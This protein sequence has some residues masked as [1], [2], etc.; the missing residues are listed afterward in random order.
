MNGAAR[1]STLDNVKVGQQ[2]YALVSILWLLGLL[3]LA[4][5]SMSVFTV[6]SL[7]VI[8]TSHDR[9]A[10][11]AMVRAGV[12]A[13]ILAISQADASNVLL[14]MT[15][16]KLGNGVARAA[17]RGETGQID[18]NTGARELVHA[19][20][21]RFGAT[22]ADAQAYII[23][24]ARARTPIGGLVRQSSFGHTGELAEIG[25]PDV[26]LRRIQPYLTV[27]SGQPRID[28]RLASREVLALLPGMTAA[29]L[30][31]LLSLRARATSDASEWANE[32]GEAAR[33]ISLERGSTV[34]IRVDATLNNGFR[35]T[36]EVVVVMFG[37]DKEPY[38]VLS[39]DESP[40]D[41]KLDL[42]DGEAR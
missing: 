22:D 14:G 13:T 28:P 32:A 31:S 17:W 30:L 4:V 16:I 27:Y 19:L 29:R 35:T 12:E 2:G 10:A 6:N 1:P 11:E 8:T 39:W 33:Y 18:L 37:D 5:T 25:I 38:R 41:R 23:S 40:P 20:F 24:I 36:A 34:R 7:S 26:L 42:L 9:V 21:R 15:E 3:A